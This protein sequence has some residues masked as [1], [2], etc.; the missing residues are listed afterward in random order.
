MRTAFVETLLEL[1]AADKNLYL[2]TGDLGF[3]VLEPF[4]AQFGDRFINAGVAE[5]NMTGVAAGLA[6]A[7]KKVFTYSIANFPTLRCLE[8]L[9]N[10]VCHHHLDVT[11][12]AVGGGLSYGA[13]GYT[14]HGL[15]DL[16]IMRTLPDMIVCAPA[17][18]QE[19]T[20]VLR[21]VHARGGPAYLRLGKAGEPMVHEAVPRLRFGAMLPVRPGAAALLLSTGGMLRST[22]AAADLLAAQ[23]VDAA[24]WSC[25][26]VRP[27][28]EAALI[29]VARRFPLLVTIE[30]ARLPGSFGGAVAE[31]LAGISGAARLRRL[32]V[33][34]EYLHDIGSQAHLR[35]RS[36]LSP[37]GIAAATIA[38]LSGKETQ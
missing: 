38:A 22:L 16:A 14:H 28:D 8:Q 25:P 23:G 30:E 21:A 3:S 7:G 31:T 37:E 4:A 24:V 29:G 10:D 20:A 2:L 27:L 6:L 32:G 5:Q 17:D 34:D 13:Q 12:V 9:R 19:T 26:F 35:A 33:R 18:P 36:G 11:V 1:A 15:E